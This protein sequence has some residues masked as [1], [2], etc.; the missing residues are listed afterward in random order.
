MPEYHRS[1]WQSRTKLESDKALA[2]DEKASQRDTDLF[3]EAAHLGK[4]AFF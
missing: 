1:S 4:V 3:V 2:G